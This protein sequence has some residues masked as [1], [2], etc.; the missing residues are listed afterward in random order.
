MTTTDPLLINKT[1]FNNNISALNEN[2]LLAVTH[3]DGPLLIVAGA[4]SGKTRVLTERIAY[5]LSKSITA[6]NILAVTFTNKAASEMKQRL[7]QLLS[8]DKNIEA[9]QIW[10]GTFHNICGRILRHDIKKLV[11]PNGEIWTNNFVIYDESDSTSLIKESILALE[12]DIKVY[13]PK[14]IKSF[15]ST[16]KTQGYD[17]KLFGDIAKNHR[18]VKIS[19]IFDAF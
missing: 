13:V 1:L 10:I 8:K 6:E 16:L 7:Y 14:N 2:Q 19:E 5:L 15:I 4:G 17:A 9:D 11:L 3:G 12:L 18:E